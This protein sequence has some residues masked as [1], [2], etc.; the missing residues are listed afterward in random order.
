MPFRVIPTRSTTWRSPT[1]CSPLYFTEH[2]KHVHHNDFLG[3]GVPPFGVR[4]GGYVGSS[5]RTQVRT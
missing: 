1:S 5:I 3:T 2:E 4:P